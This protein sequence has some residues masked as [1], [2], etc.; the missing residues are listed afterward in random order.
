MVYA[1]ITRI[2]PREWDVYNYQ[3]FWDTKRSPNPGQI[4]D[5]EVIKNKNKKKTK[6]KTKKQTKNKKTKTK[7]QQKKP[8]KK[9][10]KTCLLDF[11]VPID[12]SEN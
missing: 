11:V 8:K 5:R 10:K 9:A 3:G 2:C 1:Q 12:H 7:Q 6:Q 4:P